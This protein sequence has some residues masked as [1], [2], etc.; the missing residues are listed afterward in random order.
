MMKVQ[1]Y[2]WPLHVALWLGLAVKAR[3]PTVMAYAVLLALLAAGLARVRRIPDGLALVIAYVVVSVVLVAF[4]PFLVHEGFATAAETRPC[5]VY[6]TPLTTEC[7]E[8]LFDT[9]LAEMTRR[10]DTL[11]AIVQRS[12]PQEVEYQRLQKVVVERTRLGEH[13]CKIGFPGLTESA[14]HPW[15]VATAAEEATTLKQRGP[16][17]HW[18]FCS[19]T[20]AG[21]PDA[22]RALARQGP[23]TPAWDVSGALATFN[24]LAYDE[25]HRTYCS[26]QTLPTDLAK[27]LPPYLF[28]LATR[29]APTVPS[30]NYGRGMILAQRDGGLTWSNDLTPLLSVFFELRVEERRV[31]LAPKPF[32]TTLWTLGLNACPTIDRL[33]SRT[34]HVFDMAAFGVVPRTVFTY[35]N[36]K[37]AENGTFSGLEARLKALEGTVAALSNDVQALATFKESQTRTDYFIGVVVNVVS[38]PAPLNMQGWQTPAQL[39]EAVSQGTIVENYLHLDVASHLKNER[40]VGKGYVYEGY[41]LAPEDGT[42][43]FQIESVKGQGLAYV[44]IRDAVVASSFAKDS[45]PILL[46]AGFHF[47]EIQA[48]GVSATLRWKVGNQTYWKEASATTDAFYHRAEQ[49]DTTRERMVELKQA[50]L[51]MARQQ[52]HQTLDYLNAMNAAVSKEGL[53]VLEELR[54]RGPPLGALPAKSRSTDGNYYFS[55]PIL[56]DRLPPADA[57]KPWPPTADWNATGVADPPIAPEKVRCELVQAQATPYQCLG[58]ANEQ[59]GLNALVRRNVTGNA[60]CVSIHPNQCVWQSP[61]ACEKQRGAGVPESSNRV[62]CGQSLQEATGDAGYGRPEHWCSM[63]NRILPSVLPTRTVCRG[64]P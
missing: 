45:Q 33:L 47:M 14:D 18:A 38:W 15:K 56:P 11:K 21:G 61:E 19:A 41:F 54:K 60:E 13:A 55:L 35:P 22:L 58:K 37:D 46:T 42:Y 12:L 26:V 63:A 10:R 53:A 43:L 24:T 50:R 25:V 32:A 48:A 59:G 31:V 2:M 17:S 3:D 8:G 52:Q 64:Q 40:D 23:L 5:N 6:Y 62:E 16:P 30:G 4:H 34:V 57:W 44:R 1:V 20:E 28:L 27:A 36:A 49:V 51:Q 39:K 9:A 29:S 7:D